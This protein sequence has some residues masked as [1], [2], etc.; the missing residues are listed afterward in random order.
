M[1]PKILISQPTVQDQH[2]CP[3]SSTGTTLTYYWGHVK[4][5]W[6]RCIIW[7]RERRQKLSGRFLYRSGLYILVTGNSARATGRIRVRELGFGVNFTKCIK[8]LFS[9]ITKTKGYK[10]SCIYKTRRYCFTCRQVPDQTRRRD[11]EVGMGRGERCVQRRRERGKGVFSQHKSTGRS[12]S[13]QAWECWRPCWHWLWWCRQEA[14]P[15]M[16]TCSASDA[17]LFGYQLRESLG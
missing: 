16:S 4:G 12:R 6:F 15:R 9:T 10:S 2:V 11:R 5:P 1:E 3:L 8:N 13:A 17:W 14:E 7:W